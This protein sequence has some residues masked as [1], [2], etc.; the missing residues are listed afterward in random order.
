MSGSLDGHEGVVEL[1]V[2]E[3]VGLD[4]G[5][6]GEVFVVEHEGNIVGR[7][8]FPKVQADEDVTFDEAGTG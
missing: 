3:V 6:A 7:Q 2:A 8:R 5:E 1:A 4:G